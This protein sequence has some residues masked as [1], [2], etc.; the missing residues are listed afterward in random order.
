MALLLSYYF[1]VD[2]TMSNEF[3]ICIRTGNNSKIKHLV[4][5]KH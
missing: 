4:A 1:V 3:K 2:C 5:D